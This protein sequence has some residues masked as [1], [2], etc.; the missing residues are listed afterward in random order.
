MIK[1]EFLI[2]AFIALSACTLGDNYRQPEFYDNTQLAKELRLN[3]ANI[4]LPDKWYKRFKDNKLQAI[5]EKGL[6]NSPNVQ[7]AVARLRAAR[8]ELAI[9]R[10]EYLPQINF[11]GGYNYEKSSRNIKMAEDSH[12]Y[13]AG[14]DASWEIDIWG[15]GRRQNEAYKA[16]LKAQE[17]NLANVKTVLAAEIITLYVKWC[18][19][20]EN[21]HLARQNAA[22]QRDLLKTAESKYYSGLTDEQ[23]YNEAAYLLNDTEAQIPVNTLAAE[24]YKNALAV[25]AGVLPSELDLS[26]SYKSPLFSGHYKDESAGLHNLPA[27]VIRLRPD[28]SAAEQ[29]LISQNAL[30]GK[31]VAEL[32]PDVSI[33][34]LFGF[35]S[36]GGSSLL[37]AKSKTYNYAPVVSL[38]LLDWNRLQNQIKLQKYKTEESLVAY[39]TAVLQAVS[40]L[41]NSMAGYK[42][43]LQQFNRYGAAV[44]NMKKA[45]DSVNRKYQNGLTEFS[46]VLKAQQNLLSAQKS[47]ISSKAAINT[48]LAA[49]YKATGAPIDN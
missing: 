18:E 16:Q 44:N 27:T 30:V 5:L 20:I 28:V 6:K 17:Y 3:G 40:E 15:A 8:A 36:Q 47:Y 34:G 23:S 43:A 31:A 10:S 38:P 35:A 46:E 24:E 11:Q 29:L 37:S 12:Y 45:S 1:K 48:A 41:K 2:A 25:A 21:L 42:S 9:S 33:S 7:T 14:F 4:K 19:S 26:E 49:Y 39:K 32:Y 22:F 13:N